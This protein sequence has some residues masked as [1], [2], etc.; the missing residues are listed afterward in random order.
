M[1]DIYAQGDLWGDVFVAGGL[2][3]KI[4]NGTLWSFTGFAIVLIDGAVNMITLV[5]DLLV[6]KNRFILLWRVINI[7]Q[8]RVKVDMVTWPIAFGAELLL[9]CCL[10][11]VS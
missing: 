11:G 6:F 5:K 2:Q 8:T 4:N 1:A 7:H 9:T 10:N 3:I